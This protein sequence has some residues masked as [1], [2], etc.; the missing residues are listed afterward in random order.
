MNEYSYF[1]AQ[2]DGFSAEAIKIVI[3]S[4]KQVDETSAALA[5]EYGAKTF[6]LW[7]RPE[8]D[9]EAR[10]TFVFGNSNDVP[11]D[12]EI[13]G[14]QLDNDDVTEVATFA[15]PKADTVAAIN[16]AVQIERIL[17]LWQFGTLEDVFHSE[18]M[19]EKAVPA[20]RY[21]KAFVRSGDY[22]C[23]WD[24]STRERP[25]S[26]KISDNNS[27]MGGSN[28]AIRRPHRLDYARLNGEWYIRVPNDE[29][30][31]KSL[32]TPP[33]ATPVKYADMLKADLEEYYVREPYRRPKP[34]AAKK[35][36]GP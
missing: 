18:E 23:A 16:V 9:E 33:D 12:F 1:R 17:L 34:P 29:K 2:P 15:K 22:I 25:D 5:R 27:F 4:E 19:G 20:G 10:F 36:S 28:S 32:F 35:P 24:G 30:T 6:Q 3:D 31:G 14:I 11:A 21:S 13:T 26:G 7:N 8:G